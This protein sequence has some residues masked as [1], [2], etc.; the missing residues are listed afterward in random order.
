ML[1]LAA[2]DVSMVIV[3][4]NVPFKNVLYPKF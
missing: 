2:A 4:T 3:L 1:S